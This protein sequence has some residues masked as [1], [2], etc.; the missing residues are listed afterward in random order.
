MNKRNTSSKSRTDFDR[1]A[2]I[3][4]TDIDLSDSPEITPEQFAKAVV[5]KGLKPIPKKSQVTLRIDSD[6]LNWFKETGKGFHT[7]INMLLRAYMEQ[8]K[9]SDRNKEL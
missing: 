6:V 4:D 8:N 5:R 9:S 1:L 3:K 2:K 7:R